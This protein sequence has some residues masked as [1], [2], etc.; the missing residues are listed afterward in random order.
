MKEI[1]KSV[2]K[3]N[4]SDYYIKLK[5]IN[6]LSSILLKKELFKLLGKKFD[7]LTNQNKNNIINSINGIYADLN[8]NLREDNGGGGGGGGGSKGGS[9]FVYVSKIGRRKL[10]YTKKG[11][12]YIINKGKRKYLK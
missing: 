2:I 6:T 4:D 3:K 5:S 1:L 11:R 12:K 9:Y 7:S 8:I 10:R